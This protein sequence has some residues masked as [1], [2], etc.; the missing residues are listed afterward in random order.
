MSDSLVRKYMKLRIVALLTF[1]LIVKLGEI[2]VLQ[3]T[4]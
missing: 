1:I 4:D 2:K 3:D